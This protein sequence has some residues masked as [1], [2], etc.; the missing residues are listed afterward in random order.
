MGS[1]PASLLPT[2]MSNLDLPNEILLAILPHT[3]RA[4]LTRLLLVSKSFHA[5]A[6]PFL[7]QDVDLTGSV[8]MVDFF[9]AK[10]MTDNQ[11]LSAFVRSLK[12]SNATQIQSILPF[13]INL[14]RLA[15]DRPPHPAAFPPN[16]YSGLLK[17]ITGLTH[18]EWSD[19]PGDIPAFFQFVTSQRSLQYLGL[20]LF[21]RNQGWPYSD[22]ETVVIPSDSFRC[23]QT[24]VTHPQL[25][26]KV[27]PGRRVRHLVTESDGSQLSSDAARF[28]TSLESLSISLIDFH[29]LSG[30]DFPNLQYLEVYN[31]DAPFS[32]DQLIG[33]V[34]HLSGEKLECVQYVMTGG[35]LPVPELPLSGQIT[36]QLERFLKLLLTD[37]HPQSFASRTTRFQRAF[38]AFALPSRQGDKLVHKRPLRLY[39]SK[40]E[41]PMYTTL[42]NFTSRLFAARKP[43]STTWLLGLDAG[44]KTTLLYRITGDTEQTLPTIGFNV[45]DVSCPTLDGKFLQTTMWELG[46]FGGHANMVHCIS[47]HNR[48]PS[49]IVWVVDSTDKER[50][51]ESVEMMTFLLSTSTLQDTVPVMIL[52]NKRD[53]PTAMPLDI[54]RQAFA[55]LLSGRP[56]AAFQC[57]CLEDYDR[58]GLPEAFYWLKLALESRNMVESRQ[59]AEHSVERVVVSDGISQPASNAPVD[60]L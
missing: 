20:S 14:R 30:G 13:L 17:S 12:F 40:S 28:I 7:Y 3:G 9:N 18:L 27:L 41:P 22:I 39:S 29:V 11:R 42:R 56:F 34:H 33:F 5:L 24:L 10:L 51:D 57:S 6:E 58:G 52:A 38:V 49:A 48:N 31:V 43:A 53:L 1:A 35:S 46:Q 45:E 36:Q 55:A 60:Q 26:E 19:H 32:L 4:S 54:I 59:P 2:F 37:V 16:F 23:L 8:D 44:G 15:F 50:L 25:I 47:F 21:C